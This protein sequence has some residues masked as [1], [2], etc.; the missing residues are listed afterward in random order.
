MF[1]PAQSFARK[2]H[3]AL[4]RGFTF[5]EMSLGLVVTSLVAAALTALSLAALSGWRATDGRQATEASAQQ[6]AAQIYR[7]LR[8]ARYVGLATDD[9]TAFDN[10]TSSSSPGH[11]ACVLFWRADQAATGSSMKLCEVALIEHDTPSQT[12]RLYQVPATAANANSIYKRADIDETKDADALKG[13]STVTYQV[14]A[15]NVSNATFKSCFVGSASI[16]QTVEFVLTYA[17]GSQQT[18]RYGTAALRG[19]QDPG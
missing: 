7:M 19:I 17:S 3:S 12:L 4:A 11:G 2:S 15:S 16:H 6:S 18:V 8:S 14:L 1:C 5:V 9:G 10:G 13:L